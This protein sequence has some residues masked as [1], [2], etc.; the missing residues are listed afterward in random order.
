MKCFLA[1]LNSLFSNPVFLSLLIILL[2]IP[3]LLVN[4]GVEPLI[5]DEGIRGLVSLEMMIRKN[6]ITPTMGGELYFNKPP[7]YNW[8]L[9]TFFKIF[10]SS[11]D[12]ILRLPTV[13]FVYL[14]S[15]SIFLI[16][17][18]FYGNRVGF[19]NALAFLTC[20]RMLFYDSFKGLIDTSFSW[21][22]YLSFFSVY[23][24][25]KKEKYLLLFLIS[26]LITAL[27]FL[28]KGLPAVLFQVITLM[29]WFITEKKWQRLLSWQHLV[30]VLFFFGIIAS[31]YEAYYRQNPDHLL[32][33]IKTIFNES[34]EKTVIGAGFI[35]GVVHLFTFPFEFVFHFFPWTIFAIYL[36]RRKSIQTIWNE[37][38]LRFCIL[39]FLS[40]I[41]VY[42]VSPTTYPRYLFMFLPLAFTPIIFLHV[43]EENEGT[44]LYKI[45]HIAFMMMIVIVMAVSLAG[46]V[47]S[48]TRNIPLVMVKGCSL[49][50][51]SGFILYIYLK[52][53]KFRFEYM[54]ILLLI[55]RIGFDW[56]VI[57]SRYNDSLQPMV[58]EEI[59]RIEQIVGN[60]EI[61]YDL[62]LPEF[63]TPEMYHLTVLRQSLPH[64]DTLYRE[65]CY[66]LVSDTA[67]ISGL[68]F[69]KLGKLHT[70]KDGAIYCLVKI[71]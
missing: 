34:A 33:L 50:L 65:M 28:M 68:K 36:F 54:I 5:D 1:R 39:V 70:H 43:K 37:P 14:Y 71:E 4:L 29:V 42:W 17:R 2:S 15:S 38:Y 19:L 41:V 45:V 69:Q 23:Y 49:F 26:Y 53:I 63:K 11:S 58:Q 51:S 56:F 55:A 59:K 24:F 31:Y 12:F 44:R 10:G 3:A 32:T 57:P 16:T 48:V 46:P 22:I 66:Y 62:I 6:F 18:K 40:N 64:Y 60:N 7:L 21:F 52:N 67:K 35:P 9:I 47:L 8:I 20:G 61:H 13:V 30:S 27:T 25:S